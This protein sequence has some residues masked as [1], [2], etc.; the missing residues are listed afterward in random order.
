M[1]PY[2]SSYDLKNIWG[3]E[4]ELKWIII[5]EG[6]FY[7]HRGTFPDKRLFSKMEHF[8]SKRVFIKQ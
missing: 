6:N 4:V 3:V 8:S 2:Y 5:F 1:P 7:K